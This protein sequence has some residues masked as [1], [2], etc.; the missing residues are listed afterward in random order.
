M[1]SA[2]EHPFLSGLLGD[3]EIAALL[4]IEAEM[5]AMLRF[6]TALV[7]A[8]AELGLIPVEAAKSIAGILATF[9]PDITALRNGTA[10]E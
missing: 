4:G 3:Q 6:E 9:Q 5:A 8:Q 2:F 10:R 1:I 7:E